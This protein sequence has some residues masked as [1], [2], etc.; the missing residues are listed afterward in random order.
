MH[1]KNGPYDDAQIED[2]REQWVFRY[3][4]SEVLAA[5]EK[6]VKHHIERGKW[7]QSE[8]DKAED[9]LKKKGFEYRS[10][11]DSIG[12]QVQIVGD[13]ELAAR[14][15]ECKESLSRHKED[16]KLFETW[17]RALKAKT[18]RQPGEE[19]ELKIGDVVFFG[20]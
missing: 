15:A 4:P 14:V 6:Q 5:A 19:L 1:R 18:E 13:P 10:H 12:E 11:R 16:Q 8:S 2:L 17:T 20:L 7:W 9:L 3:K